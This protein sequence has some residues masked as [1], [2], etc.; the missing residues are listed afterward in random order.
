MNQPTAQNMAQPDLQSFYKTYQH[1]IV[2]LSA[3]LFFMYEFAQLM[4]FNSLGSAI[5][6]EF[7]LSASQLGNLSS[8]SLYGNVLLLPFAGIILDRFST[9]QVILINM[10]LCV[11]FTYIFS[12]SENYTLACISRFMSGATGAF[13]L[14]S[15]NLL[16]SRWF[17][18]RQLG[19]ITGLIVMSAFIGAYFAQT[20]LNYIVENYGWRAGV[21]ITF[22]IGL[23]LTLWM[24]LTI[25][26][27]PEEN[28]QTSSSNNSLDDQPLPILESVKQALLSKHTWLCGVYTSLTNI[29]IVVLGST[30]GSPYLQKVHSLTPIDA[31]SVTGLI[32]IGG[33]VGFP[34][35]GIL[36]DKLNS[37]K[38]PMIV[39]ALASLTLAI[40]LALSSDLSI[41]TLKIL[42]FCMGFTT[43]SQGLSYPSIMESTSPKLIA[44]CSSI[45][46][47]M[48]QGGGAVFVSNYGKLVDIHTSV[49]EVTSLTAYNEADY[50]FAYWMIPVAYAITVAIA[51]KLKE[52]YQRT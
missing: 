14:L 17:P 36:S 12:V 51:L 32:F 50:A 52:T 4:M 16:A 22:Y 5:T 30:W 13:C 49:T 23:V 35:F 44:T 41:T 39:G 19:M 45:A 40:V 37:R 29:F 25:Q 21:V 7:G 28:N 33:I 6:S 31:T 3:S 11:L 38:I 43:S 2:C 1:W 48:I 10:S 27:T 15:A 20:P 46:S 47:V 24:S 42:F 8:Q 34:I 18:S 9:R 26:D